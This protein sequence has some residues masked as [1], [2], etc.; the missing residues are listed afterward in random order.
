MRD[1]KKVKFQALPTTFSENGAASQRQHLSCFVIDDRVA[2]DAGSLAMA[3]ND[4]QKKRIRD[5]VLTHGHLD[6]IA[7]LP[8]FVDDLFAILEEPISVFALDEVVKVLKQHIFNWDVYPDFTELTNDNGTVLEYCPFEINEKFN[9][10]HLQIKPIEVNH[11]VPSVGFIITD[12]KSTIAI[13][14][15]TASSNNFW[16]ELNK[17]EKLDAIFVECAFP[18]YLDELAEASHHLTP[19]LLKTE[20]KK[21]KHSET[22]IYL[23]NLKPMYRK[24]T[25]SEVSK[26]KIENLHILEIGKVYEF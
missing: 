3:T 10:K 24:D 15:D 2:V 12:G 23:I 18:D 4:L 19:K 14:G 22:P 21:L 9:V 8:L 17:Q 16:K 26:L 7:G 13:S 25:I 20:L 6:H 1:N 5:V 11:K